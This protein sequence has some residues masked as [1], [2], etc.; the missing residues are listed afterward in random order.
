MCDC[1]PGGR[2]TA[3][4]LRRLLGAVGDNVAIN[5]SV[6]FYA[7]KRIHIGSNVRI[8]CY[9][10]L[11]AGSPNDG[12][13]RIVIGDYVHI[14]PQ[15]LLLGESGHI[16]MEDFSAISAHSVVY[17][18]TDDY[19]GGAMANATV[20][21][22]FRNVKKGDV[23]FRRHALVGAGAVIMPSVT[24]G[25]GS[26]V[27]ALSFVNRDVPDFAVV[28]GVPGRVVKQRGRQLLELEKE[29]LEEKAL[30]A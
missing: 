11:S 24:L 18:C 2:Y 15:V 12:P 14:A 27:G 29:L 23:V 1:D 19:S 28:S 21:D 16:R 9:C 6:I 7:P 17:T 5:R 30:R 22:K 25:L 8:D 3:E 4:E 20:P 26:S 13:P 10:I